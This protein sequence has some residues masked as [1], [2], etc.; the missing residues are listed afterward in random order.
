MAPFVALG[1]LG[2]IAYNALLIPI[3]GITG[4]A[5]ATFFA[6]LTFNGP[7][8]KMMKKINNF[9]ILRHLKKIVVAGLIMAMVSFLLDKLAIHVLINIAVS[10]ITYLLALYFLKEKVIREMIWTLRKTKTSLEG[11]N[12]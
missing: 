10:G 9:Q 4:A 7:I 2:N 6:Q 1:S 8:W 11:T 12:N 5:I 3:W